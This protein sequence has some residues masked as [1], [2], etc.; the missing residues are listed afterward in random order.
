MK[1]ILKLLP[2]IT[3]FVINSCS[4][5]NK[6]T[7]TIPI[8]SNPPGANIIIDG[9]SYGKTP[10]FVELKPNKNYKATISKQGYGST[11]IDM[12]TWYS[13]RGGK[14]TDSKR[15]IADVASFIV[16]YLVVLVF[17]PEKCGSFK[18]DDYFVDLAG[19][20][21]IMPEF[22]KPEFLKP[23]INN[24]N[25]PYNNQK[26]YYNN[27]PQYQNNGYQQQGNQYSWP[28]NHPSY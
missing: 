21:A 16:P 23:Q 11:N 7:V 9:K 2:V 26:S 14:G 28:T 1:N 3:L 24:Q 6:S 10:A 5:A 19:G 25:Q 8:N 17:A 13:M 27:Q 18:Q 22:L 15:C 4:F 12:E 20:K